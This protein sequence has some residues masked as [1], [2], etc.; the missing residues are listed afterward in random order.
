[1]ARR[2][3]RRRG[4]SAPAIR[5]SRGGWTTK[6]HALTDV[7]GRPYA[8]MLTPANVSDIRA[9][10]SLLKRAGRM[11]YLLGD[12]PVL[13]LSTGATMPTACAVRFMKQ[14][15][16]RHPGRRIRRRTIR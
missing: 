7:V 16:P 6:I 11:R 2:I 1:M 9:A 8:M 15:P 4:P 10:P 3:R 5:R 13:S 14:V 12:K